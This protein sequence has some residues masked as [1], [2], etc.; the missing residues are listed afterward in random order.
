MAS[1]PETTM[2]LAVW[3]H[4]R[5]LALGLLLRDE[6]KHGE[7]GK[8]QTEPPKHGR[9]TRRSLQPAYFPSSRWES[10][11]VLRRKESLKWWRGAERTA[12]IQ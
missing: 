1:W 6:H 2:T 11:E 9:V 10:H 8:Q 4:P 5:L 12:E 7:V 3:S